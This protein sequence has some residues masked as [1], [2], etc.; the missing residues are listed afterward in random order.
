MRWTR[1]VI[2]DLRRLVGDDGE[3]S[4]KGSSEDLT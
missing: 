2:E 3:E 4:G 1:R